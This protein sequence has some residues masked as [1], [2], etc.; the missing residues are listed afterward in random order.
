MN[1]VS[2]VLNSSK[3]MAFMEI[4]RSSE[5]GSM[6]GVAWLVVVFR[7]WVRSVRNGERSVT[8]VLADDADLHI[9]APFGFETLASLGVE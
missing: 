6:S 3:D 1:S 8:S 7:V 2:P 5:G 9:C 4:G